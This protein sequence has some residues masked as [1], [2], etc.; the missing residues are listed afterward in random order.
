[1]TEKDNQRCESHDDRIKNLEEKYISLRVLTE[2]IQG[3]VDNIAGRV[4]RISLQITDISKLLADNIPDFNVTKK[5][6]TIYQNLIT[7]ICGAIVMGII[8][9][10]FEYFKHGR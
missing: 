4:E 9:W 3:K 6:A 10:M 5:W 8:G 1:M 7:F 2:N